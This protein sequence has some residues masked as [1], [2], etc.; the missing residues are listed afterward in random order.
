MT[1]IQT[2]RL[3]RENTISSSVR[4]WLSISEASRFA[5]EHLVVLLDFLMVVS[6]RGALSPLVLSC[7]RR[8]SVQNEVLDPESRSA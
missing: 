2:G 1:A 6:E 4:F 3:G 8:S 7:F 5:R